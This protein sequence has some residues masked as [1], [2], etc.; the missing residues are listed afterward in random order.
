MDPYRRLRDG[1]QW[2]WSL[3]D[4]SEVARRLHPYA[5]ALVDACDIRSGMTVLDVAAGNGN[6]AVEAARRGA[7]VTASDLTPSMVELGRSR[8]EEEGLAI[9]W[10]EADAEELPF[11]SC[12]FDVVTSAF[13]A[14]FAPRPERVAA[15]MFRV[16][17]RGG[18]VAMANYTK[19]GFL[20]AFAELITEL[21]TPAPMSLPSPFQ[22]GVPDQVRLRF[23]GLASSIEVQ[24]LIGVLEFDSPEDALAFMERTNGPLLALRSMLPAERYR[25]MLGRSER[26]VHEQ[27]VASDGRAVL[28][29]GYLIVLAGVL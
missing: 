27:N 19:M 15:E 11:A 9:A 29:F 24:P 6:V 14:I 17:K 25:E 16:A 13:G 1:V 5:E 2:M 12:S 23:E 26:L 7:E 22:W 28:E 20:A 8:T 3:G 4:Y 10:K 18:K 21:A